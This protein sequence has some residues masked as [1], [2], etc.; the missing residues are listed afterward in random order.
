MNPTKQ[1]ILQGE[2]LLKENQKYEEQVMSASS[3]EALKLA[4]GF[5][6]Q[7][8]ILNL[9]SRLVKLKEQWAVEFE[10]E[11]AEANSRMPAVLANAKKYIGRE[12]K[13]VSDKI[14]AIVVGYTENASADQEK[15]NDDFYS[16]IEHVRFFNTKAK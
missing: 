11:S 5:L 13:A 3:F 15:F 2:Q 12:P 10:K 16:L 14:E 7:E 1:K 4:L 8:R 9:Q 6:F